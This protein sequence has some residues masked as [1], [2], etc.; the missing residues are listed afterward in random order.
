MSAVSRTALLPLIRMA[1][2]EDAA[3]HDVTSRA[4]IPPTTRIRAK[5]I[6]KAPGIAAG[7]RYAAWVFAE[8][9]RTLRCRAAVPDGHPVTPGQTLLRIEGNGRSI[10]AAERTALNLL[11]HLSGIATL[12]AAFVR[13]TRGT[14]ARIYDTRKTLPGLRLLEKYA[15]RAGGGCNHRSD[16]AEAVLIKTNHLKVLGQGARDRGR[17]KNKT[18][19]QEAVL[20]AKQRNPKRFVEVEVTTLSEFKA[21]LSAKP[22]AVHLDNWPLERI[23]QAV[24]LV[25]KLTP[26]APCPVPLVV[27]SGGVTLANV[28]A[29]A[30]TG[31][32]RI[33]IGRLTHSAPALDFSLVI[34]SEAKQSQRLLRRK[35]RSSQ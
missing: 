3:S 7:V 17:G 12:T 6:A 20:R 25:K 14:R 19:I 21:A 34:A 24:S 33:S 9:D 32:D 22:D 30:K 10:F 35:R 13:C 18:P 1:L 27:V 11:G 4:V 29:I 31:V 26:R 5:V 15:V 23:R 16:L 28:Q 2:K 8:Q